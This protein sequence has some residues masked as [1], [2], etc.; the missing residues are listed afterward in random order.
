MYLP[1]ATVPPLPYVTT[2]VPA[3]GGLSKG[4]TIYFMKTHVVFQVN[5]SRTCN[6]KNLVFLF[7][8]TSFLLN[9]FLEQEIFT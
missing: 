3:R 5:I 9:D 1:H 6:L 8:E 4:G 7:Q 2:F